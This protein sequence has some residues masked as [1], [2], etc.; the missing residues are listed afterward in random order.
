MVT[1]YTLYYGILESQVMFSHLKLPLSGFF[2]GG[3]SVM[4]NTKIWR[5]IHCEATL[6]RSKSSKHLIILYR[7][8]VI[9]I[10]LN[11]TVPSGS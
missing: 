9:Y 11:N 10:C 6:N 4:F 2:D 3:V 5:V 7:Q 8:I 1:L